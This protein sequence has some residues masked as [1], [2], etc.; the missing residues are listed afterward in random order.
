[1]QQRFRDW[2]TRYPGRAIELI[3]GKWQDRLDDLGQFDAILFDAYPLNEREW[4]EHY[5]NDVNY[6]RHF[7]EAAARHLRKDGVFTYYSNEADSMGRAH[8][9]AVFDWF[10]EITVSVISGLKPP[11]DCHYWQ[12]SSFLVITA[13]GSRAI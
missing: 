8:Q 13:K 11:D 3:E 12:T 4:T 1:V 10:E 7:F 5:V 2:R 9:R 6:A